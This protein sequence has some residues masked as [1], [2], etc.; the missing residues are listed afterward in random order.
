MDADE[1]LLTTKPGRAHVYTNPSWH[2]VR[3]QSS[4]KMSAVSRSCAI[5][6]HISGS[7]TGQSS[8]RGQAGVP[9]SFIGS[10]DDTIRPHG[11]K[12]PAPIAPPPEPLPFV[13]DDHVAS[14]FC[15]CDSLSQPAA[16]AAGG[17]PDCFPPPS[18]RQ[19][20]SSSSSSALYEVVYGSNATTD[21]QDRWPWPRA[22]TRC[23]WSE[24][25][26]TRSSSPPT[27]TYLPSGLQ[28]THR[29][30]PKYDRAMP[31]SS[32]CS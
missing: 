14:L 1:E 8:K 15:A 2:A 9:I 4:R 20:S 29:N 30:P 25:T 22:T 13:S 16:A 6:L 11:A 26:V 17:P 12:P 7:N 32:M 31:T 19:S 21:T 18:G 5:F 24:N 23:S 3:K 10:Y 27:T 28:H